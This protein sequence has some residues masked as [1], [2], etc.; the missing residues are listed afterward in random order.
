MLTPAHRHHFLVTD[1]MNS[2][3]ATEPSNTPPTPEAGATITNDGWFPPIDLNTL[4]S[5]MRLDGTVTHERLVDAVIEAIAYTNAQLST[6]QAQQV[7]TGYASLADVPASQVNQES[8]KL[9]H[10]RSAVYRWAQ[11]DL[12]ERYRDFDSTQSG[13]AEADQLSATVDDH[14]RAA[15]W[16]ISDIAGRQRNTVELI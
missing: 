15:H 1:L 11:A 10:Y 6:W 2:F 14:R 16:A 13:H 9:G 3:I 8:V 4:R 12:T 5:T 7:A